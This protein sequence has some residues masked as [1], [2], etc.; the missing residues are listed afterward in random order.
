MDEASTHIFSYMLNLS[1]TT[2]KWVSVN[3]SEETTVVDGFIG[4]MLLC[5]SNKVITAKGR[6]P[7]CQ[8]LVQEPGTQLR[9]QG[10]G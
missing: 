9:V 4:H 5:P 10:P 6:V 7:F 2:V 8:G 1:K 3:L